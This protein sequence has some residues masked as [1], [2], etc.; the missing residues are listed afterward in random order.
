MMSNLDKNKYELDPQISEGLS[1]YVVD[2]GA[3]MLERLTELDTRLTN[4]NFLTN[5]GGAVA[6]LTFMGSNSDP[7]PILVKISLLLFALGVIATGIEVRALLIYFGKVAK[8]NSERNRSFNQGLITVKEL[9][10]VP[11]NVGAI[12]KYVN[13]YA[14]WLSQILFC[15]GVA[16]SAISFL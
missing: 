13:H 1:Q 3:K 11:D 2:E 5:G 10:T 16:L 9:G 15:L 12:S 7:I 6:I 8:S 4:T 14:G